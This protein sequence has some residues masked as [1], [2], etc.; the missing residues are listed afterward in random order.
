MPKFRS[1]APGAASA[2]EQLRTVVAGRRLSPYAVSKLADL[3]PSVVTRFLKG[4]RSLSL[5]SFDRIFLAL[6]LRLAEPARRAQAGRAGKP[7]P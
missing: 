5:V 2:S 1:H 3:S 7:V 6:G 4:E